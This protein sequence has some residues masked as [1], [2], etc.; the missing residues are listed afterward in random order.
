MTHDSGNND[1]SHSHQPARDD[2]LLNAEAARALDAWLAAHAAGMQLHSEDERGANVHSLMSMLDG[3]SMEGRDTRIERALDTLAMHGAF[4]QHDDDVFKGPALHPL[5]DDALYA[6]MMAG[7]A[8]SRVPASLRSRAHKHVALADLVTEAD[9]PAPSTRLVDRAIAKIDEAQNAVVE[10]EHIEETRAGWFRSRFRLSDIAGIAAMLVIG[11]SIV[12]PVLG[13]FRREGMRLACDNNM[14]TAGLAF[15]S[16]MNDNADKLPATPQRQQRTWWN[17]GSPTNSSNSAN[18]YVLINKNYVHIHDLACP[19][20]DHARH[21]LPDQPASDWLSDPEVS[22]SYR[23]VAG[24]PATD[25]TAAPRTMLLTDRSPIVTKNR[26]GLPARPD[27]NSEQHG[28]RGQTVLFG[29][30]STQWL[31][32]P[33]LNAGTPNEDNI[34]L[35]KSVELMLDHLRGRQDRLLNGVEAPAGTTDNFVGP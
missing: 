12:I 27:E 33:I 13:H 23:I 28:G 22:Y 15:A 32:S 1:A 21:T 10:A 2:A 19:C 25:Q 11:A 18:L 20:N 35:P 29:D 4:D 9:V 14:A 6:L 17:V 30:G 8:P 5:D 31:T 34:W 7:F 3:V 26:R 24:V 16:Y